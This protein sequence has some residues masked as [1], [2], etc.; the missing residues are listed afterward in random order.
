MLFKAIMQQGR[1]LLRVCCGD[2]QCSE[3]GSLEAH[4]RQPIVLHPDFLTMLSNARYITMRT[5]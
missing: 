2:L 5:K 1:L 4:L 3:D